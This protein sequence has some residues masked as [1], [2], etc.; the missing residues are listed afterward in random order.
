MN[1]EE[2]ECIRIYL[3]YKKINREPRETLAVLEYAEGKLSLEKAQKLISN[4]C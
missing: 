2:R 4:N 3:A 1:N